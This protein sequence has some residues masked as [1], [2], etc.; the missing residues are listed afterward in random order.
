MVREKSLHLLGLT[1]KVSLLVPPS[2]FLFEPMTFPPLGVMYLS[3]YLK[4][5]G[6]DVIVYDYNDPN[7][8]KGKW[9]SVEQS[10]IICF[11]GTTPQFSEIVNLHKTLK[12]TLADKLW[13]IGGPHA[14]VDSESCL[15]AGFDGVVIGDGEIALHRIIQRKIERGQF[16]GKLKFFLP[17]M[18]L[19]LL[20]FPD[21]SAVDLKKYHYKIDCEEATSMITQ[22]GCP[23]SCAFCCHW[24]GY[25]ET[26]YRSPQNVVSEIQALQNSYGYRAF[27]FWDDEFNLNQIRTIKLCEALKPLQIKFRCFIR[28]NL[29]DERLAQAMRDGGCVEV[30][31]GVESGSQRILDNNNK[32][33]TVEQCTR[34]RQICR[35]HN[36]RFKAFIIVGLSGDDDGSISETKEWLRKNEPDD[37]DVT[38]NTPYP[39]SPEW[40]HPENYDLIFNK[41]KMRKQLYRGTFYKGP[42]KSP[43]ATK[44]LSAR[45]LV[46]IR[47]EI[48][49]EFNRKVKSRD[50]WKKG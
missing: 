33:T 2:P 34:A 10:E 7:S 19:D 23:Y 20:P 25:R 8:G 17:V 42:S 26:R 27:M 47:D 37:F 3:A 22:R 16:F 15:K 11:T 29:F 24:Q 6:H 43:V 40:E 41:E 44:A 4:Q 9:P 48:E 12:T 5:H 39:G 35:E 1:M 30:G 38:I 32:Q 28:A 36:I 50:L 18:N 45:R 21:W 31:C 13:I 49:D 14:S 46:E